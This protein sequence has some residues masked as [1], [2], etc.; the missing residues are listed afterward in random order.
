M[1]KEHPELYDEANENMRGGND[2]CDHHYIYDHSDLSKYTMKMTRSRHQRLHWLMRKSNIK[3][4][5]INE[6]DNGI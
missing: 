3:V 5:H 1:R 4:P 2:I 6:A